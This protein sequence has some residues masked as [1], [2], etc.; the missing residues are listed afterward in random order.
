MDAAIH[1]SKV[2]KVPTPPKTPPME[3]EL[4]N[5]CADEEKNKEQDDDLADDEHEHD[6]GSDSEEKEDSMGLVQVA[7][8]PGSVVDPNT[9]VAEAVP[10]PD[11]ASEAISQV[12]CFGSY[13]CA[14]AA[15]VYGGGVHV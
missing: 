9:L 12:R 1:A 13:C 10:A 14:Y 7:P 4:Q 8:P 5:W 15:G 6:S 2:G 11:W 3:E